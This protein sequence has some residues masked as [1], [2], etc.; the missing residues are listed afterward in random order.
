MR[1]L[2]QT[3]NF[4]LLPATERAIVQARAR[5]RR[6][7]GCGGA[8]TIRHSVDRDEDTFWHPAVGLR[9]AVETGNGRSV[10]RATAARSAL[11]S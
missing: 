1:T 9:R 5:E 3:P 7:H 6:R 4:A 10:S 2:S 8:A 11:S